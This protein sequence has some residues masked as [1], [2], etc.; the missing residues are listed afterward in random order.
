MSSSNRRSRRKSELNLE[1]NMKSSSSSSF[2]S[3]L[4]FQNI[5]IVVLGDVGRSPRMQYHAYSLATELDASVQLIGFEGGERCF[6]AI[7]KCNRISR[8][9]VSSSF[10]KWPRSLFLFYAPLKVLQQM[11]SLLWLLLFIAPLPR[12][13]SAILVQNPPS[14]PTLFV[15]WIASRIRGCKFI[16]DWHNFGY[17]VLALSLSKNHPLVFLSY[18]YEKFF[19]ARADAHLCVTRAMKS[20]LCTHWSLQEDTITVLHDRAPESFRNTTLE[21]KHSLFHRLK[22]QLPD[23]F[24]FSTSSKSKSIT[25]KKSQIKL[26]RKSDDQDETETLFTTS[27]GN[28]KPNRPALLVSSTSWTADED[29]GILLDA[30]IKV[31]KAVD[32]IP[33]L[34]LPNFLVMVTGKGPQRAMYEA[35]I[36]TLNLLHIR[37]VTAW[38]EASDYPLLLSCA[39]LGI[40]LHY[41][42]SGLD[43]PMK[44]VDMFG[45]GIPVCAIGFN[46]LDELVCHKKNGLVFKSSN[47]LALQL[48]QLFTGF[49]NN[50]AQELV[51]LREGVKEFQNERWSDHWRKNAKRIFL[52]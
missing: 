10:G 31:D 36:A 8:L 49:N 39:D 21:E 51:S 19:A 1:I 30:L 20:W 42:S 9:S 37:I 22:P 17:T 38:L 16:I 2:S 40:C 29:F 44:V 13:K 32:D 14:I 4:A 27:S 5:S 45:A 3:F 12:G 23:I 15:C 26:K 34:N 46:C 47:E 33:S 28:W 7:E 18:I 6:P 50:E 11:I 48:Q 52:Y 41:S 24:T 35:R 25:I 43:L